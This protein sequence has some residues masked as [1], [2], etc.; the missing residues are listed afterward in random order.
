MS[1]DFNLFLLNSDIDVHP[2]SWICA[3]GK[4]M[5]RLIKK[6]E[7]EAIKQGSTR[8][9]LSKKLGKKLK[10]SHTSFKQL[11]QNRRK[12]Y[13]L[14]FIAELCKIA[15]KR[16]ML[17]EINSEIEFLKVNS[18]SAGP[19]KACRKLNVSIAKV[20][21]SFMADGSL[22]V[23]TIF[24]ANEKRKLD[25]IAEMLT[26]NGQ[27]FSSNYSQARREFYLSINKNKKNVK[28]IDSLL[29]RPLTNTQSHY[30]IELSDCYKDSVLFFKNLVKSEFGIEPSRFYKKGDMWRV[31]FSNKVLARIFENFFGIWPGKK[32]DDAFEP[33]IIK[34]G[35]LK[36]RK[37]FAVGLLTFDGCIT[38]QGKMGFSSNSKKLIDSLADIWKKDNI[39]F[40]VSKGKRKGYSISAYLSNKKEKIIR[41]FEPNTQKWKLAHWLEGDLTQKP[42]I[43]EAAITKISERKILRL[44]KKKKNCDIIYFTTFFNCNQ[45]T[46]RYYLKTLK[47]QNKILLSNKVK[48]V[49]PENVSGKTTILLNKATHERLFSRIRKRFVHDKEFAGALEINK[50]TLS[51]WR[52]RN[53]RIPIQ[54]LERMCKALDL[55]FQKFCRNLAEEDREITVLK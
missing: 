26:K 50:A 45:N 38:K 15:K 14:P 18:A 52:K 31:V 19:V 44:L 54:E 11:F 39:K 43:K 1:N 20:V 6:L 37:G 55:D 46:A 35:S 29:A 40:G 9:E 42:V 17:K 23:Q 7:V 53:N 30:A 24:S 4:R 47:K 34:K 28:F 3:S 10:C 13:P 33:G 8:E 41:Y 22:S 2:R 49:N 25:S 21:G 27:K 36:I 48:S 12:F 5:P 16:K 51:S 32:S